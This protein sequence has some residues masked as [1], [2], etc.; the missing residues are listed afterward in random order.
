M[1]GE[2]VPLRPRPRTM[3]SCPRCGSPLEVADLHLAG[4]RSLVRGSCGGCGGRFVQD[5]PVGF[6]LLHP[7]SLDLDTGE[8]LAAPGSEWFSAPLRGY[9]GQ[10]DGNP[11]AVRVSRDREIDHITIL[12]CLDVVDGHELL[13]LLNAGRELDSGTDLAVLVSSWLADAVPAGVAE[14]WSVD[15]SPRRLRAWL[16]DLE[17]WIDSQLGRFQSARLSPAFPHPHSSTYELVDFT[18]KLR[19][20]SVGNPSVVMS[21]GDERL[22]GRTARAQLRNIDGLC[23]RLARRF[24]NAGFVAV[25]AGSAA[26]LP[27]AVID[28]RSADPDAA[29]ER[30][31][32]ALAAAADLVV[33]IHGPNLLLPSS[34]ARMTVE[35]VPRGSY[36]NALDATLLSDGDPLETLWRRRLIYGDAALA[37]VTAQ[38]VAEVAAAMLAGENRFRTVMLGP[39]SGR[40]G[41]LPERVEISD[42]TAV[43]KLLPGLRGATEVW[44]RARGAAGVA[45][46]HARHAIG[47]L[48]AQRGERPPRIMTDRRGLRFELVSHV[49]IGQFLVNGGH[50]EGREIEFL[51]AL[52]DPEDVV[53]DV[54]ANI[55]AFTA[56][57]A[58]AVGPGGTVHAFEPVAVSRRRLERTLELNG[59]GNVV[60][61]PVAVGARQAKLDITTY[62]PGF[63]SWATT[64]PR[65]VRLGFRVVEPVEVKT[66]DAVTLDE[67]CEER[68]IDHVAIAKIDAEGAEPA[69]MDGAAGLLAARAIDLVLFE[70]SD[71]A[72]PEGVRTHDVIDRVT[73]HGYRTFILTDDGPVPFRSAGYLPFANLLAV[74]PAALERVPG[75]L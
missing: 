67:Y 57:L 71:I 50:F 35:L 62:G 19:P 20:E 49:E 15:A 55:G 34:L 36:G 31:W 21:L 39:L 48:R 29:D 56:P 68:G 53:L 60:L 13:K 5:L 9:W 22:W 59:L 70:V 16:L 6:G 42:L 45:R 47:R 7:A 65:Q 40:G 8:T 11:V 33:G 73:R 32:L 10:P 44:R 41:E 28:R 69:V 1:R 52:A 58:R 63:E 30:A 54:G 23:R 2:A 14:V 61:N 51:V 12:N 64:V 74:A 46:H 43:P 25:G 18:R 26:R 72:L 17:T 75:A 27:S 37:R 3:G 24:P 4:W 38:R 66:V